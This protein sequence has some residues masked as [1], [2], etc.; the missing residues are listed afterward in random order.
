MYVLGPPPAGEIAT[1]QGYINPRT[2]PEFY[3]D[4]DNLGF[5]LARF[6]INTKS[7]TRPLATVKKNALPIL[8]A[9]ALFAPIPGVGMLAPKI[10]GAAKGLVGGIVNKVTGGGSSA[11]PPS[12][13]GTIQRLATTTA[14]VDLMPV[15]KPPLFTMPVQRVA[16]ST[17]DLLKLAGG[18]NT[19]AGRIAAGVAKAGDVAGALAKAASDV[20]AAGDQIGSKQLADAAARIAELARTGQDSAA[21]VASVIQQGGA[22][23]QGAMTGAVAGAT[24]GVAAQGVSEFLAT[25]PGKVSIAAVALGG[26]YLL[27]HR[28][29]G[30]G[31]GGGGGGMQRWE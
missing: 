14:N 20:G 23:V 21:N 27:L 15:Q 4:S 5:S 28:G 22:A 11:P 3:Q 2:D 25:T 7:I 12:A 1:P 24:A 16:S 13:A 9:A 31:H 8:G 19:V 30:G 17:A 26:G 10:L 6:K 29:G 18:A